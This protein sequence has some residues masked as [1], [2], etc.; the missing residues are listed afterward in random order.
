MDVGLA[1]S[2][3]GGGAQVIWSRFGTRTLSLVLV[4]VVVFTLGFLFGGTLRVGS[5]QAP[6]PAYQPARRP[7]VSRIPDKGLGRNFELVAHLPLMDDYQWENTPMGIPRGEN[8]DITAAG[9]CIYVGSFIGYQPALIVDVTDPARARVVGPVPDLVP[10][11][12]NGIE[13]IEA[14]GDLLVIDQRA[15]LDGLGFDVPQG[16]P[17][18]GLA[19]YDISDCEKPKLVARFDYQGEP[20]HTFSLWTDPENPTRVLAIQTFGA[21]PRTEPGVDIRVV[22]LTGCPKNCNPRLVAKWGLAAQFAMGPLKKVA[23]EGASRSASM[24]THEAVMSTD[25]KRI[26]MAQMQAGFFMLDSTRLVNTLRSGGKFTSTP[27]PTDCNPA[28]PTSTEAEGYCLTALNPN[29]GDRDRSVP[30]IL[31]EWYHT[32]LKVPGRPYIVLLSESREAQSALQIGANPNDELGPVRPTCPGS[33]ARILYV[34]QDEYYWSYGDER[35]L[36]RGDLFPKT[37]GVYGT[38]EQFFENCTRTGHKP[39]TAEIRAA[40]SPHDGLVFPNI[41]FITYYGGGLRAVDISNPFTPVEVGY[42][43]GKPV[44][45]VRWA[46]EIAEKVVMKPDGK[47]LSMPNSGPPDIIAFSF[48]LSYNGLLA[49]AD[50]HNGLYIVRYTGPYAGEIP[51]QGICLAGNPGAIRPGFEPCP[52]YG[53]TNW[54]VPK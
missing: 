15:A 4:V 48:V 25:G 19:I 42:F 23:Y 31:S 50:V 27:G 28:A 13:G 44:D 12:G 20:T 36:M 51:K 37:V 14:R 33:L 22:D 46:H 40:Y 9:H 26:Y 52:P 39:G 2:S 17:A 49:Y 10:G 6:P 47:A 24:Q 18:R 43:F 11:V 35:G 41:M 30:P 5:A 3:V 34:G 38:V 8:G 53:Q 29:I 21:A 32:P 1:R 45:K 7:P 54:G 16:L